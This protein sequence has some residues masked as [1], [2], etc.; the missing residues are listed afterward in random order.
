[1]VKKLFIPGPTTVRDEILQAQAA[2]MIGHRTKEYSD[3]QGRVTARLQKLLFTR[4]RVYL[5]S[6]SATGVMEGAIRQA[7]HKKALI[8]VCGAFSQRWYEIALAN[9]VSADRLEVPLG[10]AITPALVDQAL[11]RGDYDALTL[12]MNETATGI[13]NPVQEIAA[14]V[15]SKYPETLILVDAASCMAGV[16]IDFDAWG[17]DVCFAG[18][19]DCFALPPG[20]AV[21]AVSQRARNRA[22]DIP[23]RGYYFAYEAM[24]SKYDR[25]QTPATPAVSLIQAMDRQMD[26]ILAEGLENRWRRHHEMAETVRLWARRYFRLYGDEQYLSDTVTNIANTRGVSVGDLNQELGR[27]GAMIANGYAELKDE[28]FRIAHMGDLTLD[29]I[30][31][32][33]AQIDEIL[34]LGS[35]ST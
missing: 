19:Q 13:M 10:K 24:D 20:L 3:L 30:K 12:T 27:R 16:K 29:D 6:A 8:T 32:L 33:L 31:W 2:A 17:L 25:S 21:C 22:K 26:C 9:G 34:G 5:F 14:L 28:C 23:S 15:R 35:K 11:S 18:S 1:M 4:Q 7:A